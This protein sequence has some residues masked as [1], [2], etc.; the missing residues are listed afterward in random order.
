[1]IGSVA[2]RSAGAAGP[3]AAQ[4]LAALA[5]VFV[6]GAGV[7]AAE[8]TYRPDLAA[9][10]GFTAKDAAPFLGVPPERVVAKAEK[11][12]AAL[13]MCSF[14]A[15]TAGKQVAFSLEV[16]KDPKAA[17]A[18]MEQYRADLETAAGTKPF[19]DKL[20]QG[21]WSEILGDGVGDENVW[22]DVNGSFTAR[23]GNVTV[24][25]TQPAD[26]LEKIKVGRAVLAKL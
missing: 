12:H 26:K 2:I 19:K 6:P 1:M 7:R 5:L 25:V 9:C 18:Q 17:A 15:G 22:T 23:K 21:A 13:W 8:K 4:V 20:P 11:V 3:L 14:G 24:Q 10:A 16:A